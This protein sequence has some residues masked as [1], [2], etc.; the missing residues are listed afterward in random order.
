MIDSA[1]YNYENELFNLIRDFQKL[2]EYADGAF[3]NI[4][5]YHPI[6]ECNNH[7]LCILK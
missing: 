3:I 2:V 7:C 6:N 1:N 4:A 5:I